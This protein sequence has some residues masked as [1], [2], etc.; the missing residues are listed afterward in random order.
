MNR[1]RFQDENKTLSDF[2]KEVLVI[3]PVCKQKAVAKADYEIKSARLLCNN[4]GYNKDITTKSSMF[5]VMGNWVVAAHLYFDA[6]LWLKAPFKDDFF[7][8]YN[9]QHL[10]YLE[11]YIS[12]GLREH[13]DRTHFTLLEKLPKFYHEAKNRESLLK[14]IH[15]LKEK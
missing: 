2:Q 1:N 15:K 12:A 8:A 13:K 6:D 11:K 4:C 5:G 9:N 3:C 10:D 7:F 14:L